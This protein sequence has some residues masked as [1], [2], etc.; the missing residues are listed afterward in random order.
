MLALALLTPFA[1]HLAQHPAQHF[2]PVCYADPG[3][4]AVC[5]HGKR[6]IV[7]CTRTDHTRPSR[8][9]AWVLDETQPY[10]IDRG[11]VRGL[12]QWLPKGDS[13]IEF[14]A[15]KGCYTDALGLAGVSVRGFEG[16]KGVAKLTRG[17]IQEADLTAAH[18]DLGRSDW[19]MLVS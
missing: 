8:T 1:Q 16:A 17:L 14:G 7:N 4:P 13:V 3:P 9:G 12:V 2:H 19:V 6:V 18:L 11:L 10:L 15:G 5:T